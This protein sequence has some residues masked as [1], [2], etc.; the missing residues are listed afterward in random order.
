MRWASLI[1]AFVSLVV[2]VWVYWAYDRSAAGFQFQEEFNLVPSLGI[3]YLLGIDGMSALMCL[4]TSIIIFA[5]VFASWTVKERSQEFYALLLLLVTGVFGVFVSLDLFV[6]FLF[7]EIAVLPMYLLIG[8]WDSTRQ[9]AA[10]LFGWA[11][12]RTGVGTKSTRDEADAVLLFGSAFILVGILAL[13]VVGGA[14]A[15]SFV[16]LHAIAVRSDGAVLGVPRVLHRLRHPC[17]HLAA[18]HV[19]ARWSPPRRRPRCRCCTP[20]C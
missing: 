9:P 11:F 17:R 10:G 15:F 14:R 16:T 2:S 3:S 4:L 6:F 19:V 8:I 5:G 12:G 18:A 1:G 7:Y 20:A 13:Y